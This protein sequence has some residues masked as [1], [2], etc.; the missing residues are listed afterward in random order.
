[1]FAFSLTGSKPVWRFM[2]RAHRDQ[3]VSLP[4]AGW[5]T[6]MMG[7]R[8]S[9][10]AL[11]VRSREWIGVHLSDKV[12]DR[13]KRMILSGRL[14]QQASL[15]E[16]M[17]ASL[18][19]VSRAPVREAI[20]ELEREGLVIVLP[21]SGLL[22]RRLSF[23]EVRELYEI[24]QA[25][26][27]MA[28]YLCAGRAPEPAL[29]AARTQLRRLAARRNP[30]HAAIQKASAAFHRTLFDVAGNRQLKA[31]YDS[32]E[33]RIQLN[34]RLT[35]VHDTSRIEQSLREHLAIVD[36]IIAK[37]GEK[38]ESLMRQH[39]ENGKTARLRILSTF[40][41]RLPKVA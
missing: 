22:I 23:D 26:E 18:L 4:R 39:L 38:A 12:Y 34:L 2:H 1:M 41:E 10:D 32:V 30:D 40:G 29:T 35:A 19:S 13:L 20:Q 14:K 9:P 21:R 36:A 28:A 27:G 24:R 25:L 15:S 16:R 7:D 6:R 17:L 5:Y 11:A 37:D 3:K 8:S 31:L 33:P